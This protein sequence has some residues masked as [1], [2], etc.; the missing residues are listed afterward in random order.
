[1]L[2]AVAVLLL[3]LCSSDLANSRSR[4]ATNS[5]IEIVNVPAEVGSGTRASLLQNGLF[6][7]AG[8]IVSGIAGFVTVPFM[9]RWIGTEGYGLVISTAA[10][11]AIPACLEN[12]LVLSVMREVAQNRE[13]P[14]PLSSAFLGF[15][16]I[17]CVT[18][19]TAFFGTLAIG[20]AMHVKSSA[21]LLSIALLSLSFALERI[22]AF[23]TAV[24]AG[25]ARFD[26]SNLLASSLV[27]GRSGVAL[28]V[29]AKGGRLPEIAISYAACSIVT[30]IVALMVCHRVAHLRF[31]FAACRWEQVKNFAG[32]STTVM[33]TGF[34]QRA[35]TDGRTVLTGILAGGASVALLAAGEK[36]PMAVANLNWRSAETLVSPVAAVDSNS[37]ESIQ[38]LA[39]AGTRNVLFFAIPACCVLFVGAPLL[40]RLWI[41]QPL[42]MTVSVLRITALAVLVDAAAVG[43]VH[44]FWASGKA[45][46]MLR[47]YG[48]A[49]TF[50]VVSSCVLIP[51]LGVMGAAFG[52]LVS[53]IVV[54]TLAVSEAATKF[55]GTRSELILKLSDGLL[56]PTAS[57]CIVAA[58]LFAS[59]A[60][61]PRWTF[62]TAIAFV[63]TL[64]YGFVLYEFSLHKDERQ[65][66]RLIATGI[67]SKLQRLRAR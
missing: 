18:C 19:L 29:M 49:A 57:C 65:A 5:R 14:R 17:A 41:S 60:G 10:V 51:R 59:R 56:L 50:C 67:T 15:V 54:L 55:G 21:L 37:K 45:N 13:T 26:L 22:L 47:I 38:S 62:F 16:L 42:P 4:M 39:I 27:V 12:G 3:P 40:V 6:N 9:L 20:R 8:V 61:A 64:V 24:L 1:M 36:F 44:V 63:S 25:V 30:V 48:L 34:L 28:I 66:I 23:A 52:L 58:I 53:T 31:H 7:Y 11:S 35:I 46:V 33:F 2:L 32:F 43:V